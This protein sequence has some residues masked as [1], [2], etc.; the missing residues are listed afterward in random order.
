M[1][2][3]R[4]SP[5]TIWKFQIVPSEV[6]VRKLEGRGGDCTGEDRGTREG[7]INEKIL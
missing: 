1:S 4:R 6:L 2:E 7:R 3:H 5:A